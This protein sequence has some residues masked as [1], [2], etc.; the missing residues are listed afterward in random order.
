MANFSSANYL[1]KVWILALVAFMVSCSQ[2]EAPAPDNVNMESSEELAALRGL[3]SDMWNARTAGPVYLE[4]ANNGGNVLCSEAA[5]YFE[6]E[7]GFSFTSPDPEGQGG[8]D[9]LGGNTF[10][11][12]FPDG[13]TVTVTDNKF[14][15]WSFEPVY[16]DGVKYCLKNL[17]VLVKGGPGANAYYYGNGET[18]DE[19]L[20]SPPVGQGNTPDLS[21]LKLC[22]NLEPCDDEKCWEDETAW[23][24]GTRYVTKGNWATYSSKS[25]LEAGVTLF[26]G[27][28]LAAGTVKLLNG[29]ITITLNEGWRFA[30]TDENVKIQHYSSTPPASN[31]EPGL[32]TTKGKANTSPYSISVPYGE[33]YG[34]HVD[35][36]RSVACPI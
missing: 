4:G 29:V 9:Y 5:D 6:V 20:I 26:A 13:F 11:E 7:G 30:D 34:V 35:V 33:F 27:Q 32:F 19:G 2:F 28:T 25:A 21:N 24:A 1:N 8:N 16:I 12:A 3:S 10:S 18:S 15:S 31:P 17:V 14:V 36:E 23:A 22:Y